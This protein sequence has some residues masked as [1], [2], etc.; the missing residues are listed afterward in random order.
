MN[1]LTMISLALL[2]MTGVESGVRDAYIAD[3]KNCIFTCYRDSYCK[4]ECIKNGAETGYCIW[5]GEYGN[6]CWCIKLPNKVPIKVPGKCN[7]R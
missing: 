3:N 4:T 6:A 1:Y 7:G 5:I 2:V